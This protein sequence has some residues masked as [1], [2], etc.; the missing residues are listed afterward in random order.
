MTAFGALSFLLRTGFALWALILCAA[1]ITG[2]VLSVAVKRY[3]CIFLSLAALVPSCLLWQVCYDLDLAVHSTSLCIR[4]G[5][6]PWLMWLVVLALLTLLSAWPILLCV[7]YA[8]RSITPL[9]IK[10]CADSMSC[11]ICYWRENGHVIFANECMNRLCVSLTGEALM[12][13]EHFRAAVSGDIV[14]IGDGVWS[15]TFRDLTFQ[16]GALHEMVASDVSELHEKAEALRRDNE[17][18]SGMREELRAYGLRIDDTVRRQEIL[19]AKVN[20][21]DEMNRLMLSTVAMDIEN[22]AELHRNFSLWERN[23]LQLCLEAD[24]RKDEN[25]A[26]QLAGMAQALG[27]RLVWREALPDTITAQRRE[28]FFLAAQEAVA[29]AVKH[30]GAGQLRITF[31]QTEDEIRCTFENDGHVPQGAV[32]FT[33]GLANLSLLA[34]EQN[35]RISA[36]SGKTFRL[37][38]CFAKNP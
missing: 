11:G 6:F 26:A 33:G 36:E 2:G 37:S 19:Q 10:R 35:A 8:G 29:N 32:R 5:G 22:E 34:A 38:L 18:L 16:G 27:L 23:A 9:T 24:E 14:P 20:I 17:T 30:A 21:H 13:G 3:R 25:A 4:L 1:G 15:F 12:N 31:A 28:L 7:R